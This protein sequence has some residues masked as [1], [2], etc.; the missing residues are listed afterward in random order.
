[1]ATTVT[2]DTLRDA[3]SRSSPS[4]LAT[5]IALILLAALVCEL[6]FSVRNQSQTFDEACHIFAGYS[7]WKTGDF[8]VNPEHPPLLKLIATLPLLR[9]PLRSP[10]SPIGDFKASEYA[11]GKEFLY[12]NN[13]AAILFRARLA[14]ASVTL[15][16]ALS[17]F[18]VSKKLFGVWPAVV[19]L[20]VFVFEPNLLAHGALVTTDI[21]VSLGLFSGVA[22]YLF[23]LKQPNFWRLVAAGLAAGLCLSAKH[24][25]IL[26]LP[27]VLLIACESLPV[28][29]GKSS[30]PEAAHPEM[31]P[32]I[33]N[34]VL[35]LM[36]VTLISVL[37]LWATY[38]FR[39]AARPVGFAMMPQ[40]AQFTQTMRPMS[41]A[42]VQ[43]LA[44]LHLLP[45]AYL[46]GVA[47]IISPKVHP[48]SFFGRFYPSAQWFFFPFVLLVK[49]TVAFLIVILA[50]VFGSVVGERKNRRDAFVLSIPVVVYV[51]AAFF[52]GINYGI[53]HLLPIFPFLIVIASAGVW[54]LARKNRLS[55]V[56]LAGLLCFHAASSLHAYPNYIPYAN[57]LF[58]GP[59]NA[60]RI[61]ADSN[62][63]WGQG[64]VETRK[65]LTEPQAQNCWFAYF[66]DVVVDPT[67]YGVHCKRLPTGFDQIAAIPAPA[68]PPHVEG[69]VLISTTELAGVYW[70]ARWANPYR[71]FQHLRPDAI[72]GNSILVFNGTVDISEVAALSHEEASQQLTR[73]GFLAQALSEADA[74]VALAPARPTAHAA[75]AAALTA[76]NRAL[77]ADLE[78]AIAQKLAFSEQ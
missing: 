61:L 65:Y 10:T 37:V 20:A 23:Y 11:A 4:S 13:A 48:T 22:L 69:P 75:R 70:R 77:D 50:G 74:A 57:E 68:L 26:L 28:F 3:T 55:R 64:L 31:W 60:Y 2:A 14:A 35:S 71:K 66:G 41:A 43:W 34:R 18:L 38:D 19:G 62:V 6:A 29:A 25:G 58:G 40:L 47:D 76:L 44:Q 27:I 16:L 33:R 52:S 73:S 12:S 7:Y 54:Q 8:G 21:A 30:R 32:A 46:F 24:S 45:E 39:F 1:M 5:A 53:R 51:T 17:V 59:S 67:D 36:V 49:S 42:L 63:D 15:A 78:R 72:I 9:I 56:A